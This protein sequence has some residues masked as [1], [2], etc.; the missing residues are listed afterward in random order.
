LTNCF[1]SSLKGAI[2]INV[3]FTMIIAFSDCG[4]LGKDYVLFN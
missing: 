3:S 1:I 4:V 2:F